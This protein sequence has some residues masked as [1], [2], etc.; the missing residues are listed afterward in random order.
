MKEYQD[1][2]KRKAILF[3]G[4]VFLILLVLNLLPR[5]FGDENIYIVPEDF[6]YEVRISA[7]GILARDE[8]LYFSNNEG[9]VFKIVK[10]GE[11]VRVGQKVADIL[12]LEDTTD[13]K[14]ELNQIDNII[15]FYD[16]L[17]KDNKEESTLSSSGVDLLVSKLYKQLAEEDYQGINATKESIALYYETI[18]SLSGD[19][20]E[21][22][23][24]TEELFIR[25][26]QLLS[27][28]SQY[29]KSIH[30]LDSGIV[31]YEVDGWEDFLVPGKLSELDS[32]I[33]NSVET[34]ENVENEAV[35]KVIDDYQWHL[36]IK[37]SDVRA[38]AYRVGDILEV[39]ISSFDNNRLVEARMPIVDIVE[40]GVDKL[41]VLRGTNFIEK[42]FDKRFVD[43]EIVDFREKTL[44]IPADAII[45]ID[46]AVGVKVKE[47]YGVVTFRPVEIVATDNR[48]A[49]VSKG[50]NNGYIEVGEESF[51]TISLFSEVI[52][53]PDS[54]DLGEILN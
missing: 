23:L 51:R 5:L 7:Q 8:K 20:A 35:F 47:F 44:K 42:V 19:A 41:Y 21:S 3:L 53:K 49:Y 37:T 17:R 9:D 25:R 32:D 52:G 28:I 30:S 54:V 2:I 31:S 22:G 27:R 16:E 4:F 15:Q 39:V 24:T 11:R 45:E 34:S 50:D 12:L 6:E 36:L 33:F 14:E 18:D 48:Y 10:E 40:D 46:G 29:N 1:D 43:V 13:L 38:S 26:E